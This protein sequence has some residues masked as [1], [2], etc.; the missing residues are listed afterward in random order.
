M[1]EVVGEPPEVIVC[2]WSRIVALDLRQPDTG[3]RI[4]VDSAIADRV[5]EDSAEYAQ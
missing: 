1:L 2:Q 3:R 4:A 5:I